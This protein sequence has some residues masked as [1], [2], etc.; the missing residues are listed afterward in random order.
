MLNR[1]SLTFPGVLQPVGGSV[2]WCS[3]VV[4]GVKGGREEAAV[5]GGGGGASSS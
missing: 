3:G 4:V 2:C 5:K 1:R